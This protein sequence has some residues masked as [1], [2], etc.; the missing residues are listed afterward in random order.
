MVR[1]ISGGMKRRLGRRS[2]A[3]LTDMKVTTIAFPRDLHA[4]LHE[5][6]YRE[7]VVLAQIVRRACEEWLDREA[8]R[9]ER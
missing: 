1:A 4:R 8:K 2:E 5:A 6:A 7:G 3:P 9:R